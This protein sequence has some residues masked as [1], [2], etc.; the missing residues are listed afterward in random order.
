MQEFDRLN[1]IAIEILDQAGNRNPTQ[2]QIDR[3]QN[4]L[5]ILDSKPKNE[6]LSEVGRLR[7]RLERTSI[8]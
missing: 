6:Q 8:A 7:E 1:Y 4:L 5:F 2:N 3:V